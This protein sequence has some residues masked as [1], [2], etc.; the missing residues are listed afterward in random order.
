MQ[1]EL[2]V[3]LSDQLTNGPFYSDFRGLLSLILGLFSSSSSFFP[4]RRHHAVAAGSISFPFQLKSKVVVITSQYQVYYN[5]LEGQLSQSVK[6]AG[7]LHSCCISYIPCAYIPLRPEVDPLLPP[8][9]VVARGSYVGE[10][11]CCNKICCSFFSQL[12]SA[13]LLCLHTAAAA[14]VA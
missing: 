1:T 4:L 9:F 10:K 12:L 3:C 14:A 2:S 6:T 8:P 13:L 7:Y 5:D 11:L